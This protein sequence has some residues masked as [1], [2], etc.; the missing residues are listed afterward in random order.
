MRQAPVDGTYDR[1]PVMGSKSQGVNGD[2]G[3]DEAH[4]CPWQAV[5]DPLSNDDQGQDAQRDANAPA[6]GT[7]DLTGER[8]QPPERGRSSALHPQDDR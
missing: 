5:V 6:V 1:H 4:E 8:A 7:T 2:D 3:Q